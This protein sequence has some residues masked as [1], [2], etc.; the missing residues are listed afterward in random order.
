MGL[1]RA[2]TLEYLDRHDEEGGVTAFTFR[3]SKPLKHVAGQHGFFF[4]PG[5]GMKPFSIASAPED[6]DIVI[7][8][9]L[10]SGSKFKTA[11]AALGPG[12]NIK[13][14]GPVMRFTLDGSSDEVVF[15]AQGVGITPF[16]SLLRHIDGNDIKKHTTLIHVA[17]AHPFRTETARLA[18]EASY[19]TDAES[20]R[21][22]LK[23]ASTERPGATYYL[24]GAPSFIKETA[25]LLTEARIP[26]KQLKR[27]MFRGY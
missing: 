4:V 6:D 27:D 3:P 22:D 1:L 18:R 13:V 2:T 7:A 19:P 16:R 17:S 25:A 21:L 10:Q 9:K 8:T 14:R 12:E 26:K 24:S 5:A 23:Q 20:F 15:I 11:L